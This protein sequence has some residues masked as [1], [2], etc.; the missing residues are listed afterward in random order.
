MD[1]VQTDLPPDTAPAFHASARAVAPR[2]AA[3]NHLH[4]VLLAV[5]ALFLASGWWY[6]DA[7]GMRQPNTADAPPQASGISVPALTVTAEFVRVV[8]WPRTLEVSGPI[9]PWQEAIVGARV[10]GLTVVEVRVNVGDVVSRGQ[11][12]ARLDTELLRSDEAQ[13]QASVAQAEATLAQAEA[14]SKRAQS[15]KAS[16]GISEQDILGSVTTASTARAQVNSAKATL[17]SKRLQLN[18]GEVRSPDKGTISSRSATIGGVAAVG[19][20]MFRLIMHNRLE[21]RGELTANQLSQIVNGQL[22]MLTLPDG[23]HA[24]ARV[25]QTSPSLADKSRLAT[26]YADVDSGSAARANMYAA[27][28]IA[29]GQ[30]PGMAVPAISVVIRDGHSYV[31]TLEPRDATSRVAIRAVIVGRRVGTDVEIASGLDGTERVVVQGAGLL[32]DRDL[33]RIA[34]PAA[35]PAPRPVSL[36]RAQP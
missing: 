29:I 14:N 20:E 8:T 22:V 9:A 30:G 7:S 34:D 26:V 15:L 19:Q 10:G 6:L 31:F 21:W 32:A 1:R 16:G 35:A 25:R 11:I 13:L 3:K 17:L 2:P 5:V 18:Y 24:T 36:A 27:A 28:Q 33:V 12:L 23:S 4:W